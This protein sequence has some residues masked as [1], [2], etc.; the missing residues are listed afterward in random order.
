VLDH[1]ER[2]EIPGKAGI[3][4]A[5]E[6]VPHRIGRELGNW[7]RLA[8]HHHSLAKV[9]KLGERWWSAV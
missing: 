8:A 3:G 1:P 7:N 5:A 6:R 4:H 9:P 2:D